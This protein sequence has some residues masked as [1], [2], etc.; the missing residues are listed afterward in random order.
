MRNT[1]IKAFKNW[2]EYWPTKGKRTVN[3]LLTRWSGDGQQHL[4]L[5]SINPQTH[6]GEALY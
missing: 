1:P 5:H 4:Q 2:M 3:L 6:F